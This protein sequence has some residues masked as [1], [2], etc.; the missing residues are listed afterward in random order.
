[1]T[2]PIVSA[3]AASEPTEDSV[4][5]TSSVSLT[6]PQKLYLRVSC[7]HIDNL[8]S[9]IE[10]IIHSV[11]SKSPFPKY[12]L[13]MSPAQTRVIEDYIRRLRTQLVRVLAWQHIDASQPTIPATR[14]I[15]TRVAFVDIA[16]DELRPKEMR[17]SGS[18]TPEATLQLTGVVRELGALSDGLANYMSFGLNASLKN[19]LER[20]EK[21]GHQVELLTLLEDV[22]TRHGMVEF[23]PR[24]NSLTSRLEDTNFEV[25]VFGRVSSGKSSLLN[26]LLGF[27]LLPIGINP[28]TAVPTRLQYGSAVKAFVTYGSSNEREISTTELAELISERSNPGNLKHVS[29]AL[30]EV[31]SSRLSEGIVLVDTPGLGSL[32][33]RGAAET[34]AYL[35]SCDLAILLIDAG[36]TLNEEDIGTLRIIDEAGIS[37][38]VLLS[39]AD[40]LNGDEREHAVKYIQEQ[41]QNE[42]HT[43]V[44]VHPVSSVPGSIALLDQFFEEELL[45]RFKQGQALRNQSVARKVEILRLAVMASLQSRISRQER[46]ELKSAEDFSGLETALR[47][48]TGQV[49]ELNASLDR[50]A[51]ELRQS[52]L[53]VLDEVAVEASVRLRDSGSKRLDSIQLSEMLHA[54]MER[55]VENLIQEA[56]RVARAAL[57]RLQEIAKALRRPDTPELKEID[58]L[59]RDMPRFEIASLPSDIDTGLWGMLG[60]ATLEYR[61]KKEIRRLWQPFLK[62][63]LDAY[64]SELWQWVRQFGRRLD[65]LISSYADG[66]RIQIQEL[67]GHN[68]EDA[69]VPKMKEDLE[70]LKRWMDADRD[71][72][73][74]VERIGA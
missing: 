61:L 64:S 59:L 32:A 7:Q 24:L 6:D 63:V 8:L 28:I 74:A 50:K 36:S 18:L 44:D 4:T 37:S 14:A 1:M 40:L 34:L 19:R 66:Y 53:S 48:I 13:D 5:Q 43:T 41:V 73:E 15:S 72:T 67:S 56:Q 54:A 22:V 58:S 26:K 10:E 42:L 12:I 39:K 23:R 31:P 71:S 51:N 65:S 38:L 17:G 52:G 60:R 62:N 20:L 9:D 46:Q 16:L 68:R 3:G 21:A 70:V 25:A 29:R 2:D 27:D 33:R 11:E 45:P 57:V 69:D 35:P 47:E 49:G 30:I 55:K